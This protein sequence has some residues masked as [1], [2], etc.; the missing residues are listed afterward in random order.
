VLDLA[1]GE[2]KRPEPF[3]QDNYCE[4]QAFPYLLPRGKFGLMFVGQLNY[5]LL[6]ISINAFLIILSDFHHAAIIFSL[7]IM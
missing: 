7:H 5:L 3:F 4:E 6:N 1:P 2:N